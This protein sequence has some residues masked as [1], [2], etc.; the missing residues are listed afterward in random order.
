MCKGT[1]T[2][3]IIGGTVLAVLIILPLIFGVVTHS[4]AGNWGWGRMGPGMMYGYGGGWFMGIIMIFVCGLIICGIIALVRYLGG[5]RQNDTQGN[6]AIEILKRRFAQGEIN[7]EEF[8][9]K[10]KAL[11]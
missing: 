3:F 7:K 6:S 10:K 8:E 2:A 11:I 9:E 1:K 4:G 5:T